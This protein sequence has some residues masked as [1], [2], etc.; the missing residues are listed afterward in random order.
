MKIN[1]I[2]KAR[3]AAIA[4]IGFALSFS[5]ALQAQNTWFFV[6]GTGTGSPLIELSNWNSVADGSG[7]SPRSFAVS[8]TWILNNGATRV[9]NGNGDTFAPTLT[10]QGDSSVASL[11]WVGTKT[12]LTQANVASGQ[13]LRTE[14][15]SQTT[16]GLVITTFNLDGIMIMRGRIHQGVQR[17]TQL[18]VGTLTGS[19]SLFAGDAQQ[20]REDVNLSLN[21]GNA[22]DFTGQVRF[23]NTTGGF[24]GNTDLSSAQLFIQQA[25]HPDRFTT[26]DVRHNI[27]VKELNIQGSIH[28]AAATYSASDLTNLLSPGHRIRF[29]DNVGRITVVP[30]E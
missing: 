18:H 19:G 10:V 24:L 21:I 16:C 2:R 29:L 26:F 5:S 4:V 13:V 17:H 28:R 27:T 12:Y 14:G 25:D 11:N 22:F 1:Y 23:R 30:T 15:A 9:G 7:S 6:G 20:G 8:D 3:I